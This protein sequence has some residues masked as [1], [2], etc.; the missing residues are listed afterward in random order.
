M[1]GIPT[2]LE[3]R[4]HIKANAWNGGECIGSMTNEEVFIGQCEYAS[5]A[6]SEMLT[7]TGLGHGGGDWSLRKRGWYS[8]DLS[9]SKERSGCDPHAFLHGKHCHSWVEYKGMI[10]DAT[11]WQ[12]ANEP[13][14]VYAFPIG[15][16]RYTIDEQADHLDY[17]EVNGVSVW[18][19]PKKA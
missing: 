15:D 4:Q 10:Y 5:T 16:S 12:F 7:G 8:G 6:I 9:A 19:V 1:P 14:M 18:S 2:L 11:Y 13:I 17:E 3:I